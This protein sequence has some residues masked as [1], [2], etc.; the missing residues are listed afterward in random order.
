MRLV[1]YVWSNRK[2]S[3]VNNDLPMCQICMCQH[4]THSV[5]ATVIVQGAQK[6][7]SRN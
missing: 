5:Y 3:K 7:A 2:D 6:G 4:W 1:K